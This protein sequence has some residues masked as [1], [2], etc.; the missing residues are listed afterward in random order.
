MCFSFFRVCSGGSF[1]GRGFV[2]L[3]TFA[4]V[5]LWVAK[6]NLSANKFPDFVCVDFF[7]LEVAFYDCAYF[8]KPKTLNLK[9][10]TLNLKP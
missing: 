4:D 9:P 3:R 7:S 10:K 6:Q 1:A 8:L 5:A 2:A